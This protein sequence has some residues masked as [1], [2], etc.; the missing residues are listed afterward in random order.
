MSEVKLMNTLVEF[1]F[2][3]ISKIFAVPIIFVE[4]VSNGSIYDFKTNGWAAKW[5]MNLGLCSLMID[6]ISA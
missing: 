1:N 4:N 2:L 5:N 3:I 6:S